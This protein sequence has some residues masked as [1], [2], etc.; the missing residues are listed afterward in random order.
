MRDNELVEQKIEFESK[1][2][3]KDGEIYNHISKNQKLEVQLTEIQA[4]YTSETQQLK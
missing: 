4:Q 3:K 1:M 2:K